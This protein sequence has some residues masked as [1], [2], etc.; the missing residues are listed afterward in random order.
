MSLFLGMMNDGMGGGAGLS[1]AY[2]QGG[3]PAARLGLRTAPNG[4]R[5]LGQALVERVQAEVTLSS[6]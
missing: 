3:A 4:G 5:P 2:S 1:G 6:G